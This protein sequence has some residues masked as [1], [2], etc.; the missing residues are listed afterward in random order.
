MTSNELDSNL[1]ELSVNL[2]WAQTLIK[3]LKKYAPTGANLELF[4][5][6]TSEA[7][8]YMSKFCTTVDNIVN[9]NGD[10][11]EDSDDTD[12][13]VVNDEPEIDVENVNEKDSNVNN[14]LTAGA[15]NDENSDEN[16]SVSSENCKDDFL[17]FLYLITIDVST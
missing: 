6:E 5:R 17:E 1:K 15:L 12:V 8:D 14:L 11:N 16:L 2:K 7:N 13:D 3:Q 9:E 4:V 10:E